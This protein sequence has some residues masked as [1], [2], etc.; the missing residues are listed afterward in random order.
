MSSGAYF[1]YN[2]AFAA[3]G[4][5]CSATTSSKLLSFSRVYL[6][7]FSLLAK[8]KAFF[9]FF[10]AVEK[11]KAFFFVFFVVEEKEEEP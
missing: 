1:W 10:W 4:A 9:L 11:K 3:T 6:L 2:R 7:G 8:K 5:C